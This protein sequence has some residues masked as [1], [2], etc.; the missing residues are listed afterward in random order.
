KHMAAYMG[1]FVEQSRGS[2]NWWVYWSHIRYFFYVYSYAS[3]LLISKSLQHSV[4]E[5]PSFVSRVKGF[6][7]AGLSDSPQNIFKRLGVDI[8]D[9][10]FWNKGLDEVEGLLEETTA[11]ARRLGKV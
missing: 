10:G 7:A 9:S 2:E 4:K 5:D 3:G 1:S 8:T 11:L 6:L